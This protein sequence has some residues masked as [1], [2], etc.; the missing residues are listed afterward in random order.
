[1]DYGSLMAAA[2]EEAHRARGAGEVPIGAVVAMNAE[3]G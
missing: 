1:M 3:I 2:L